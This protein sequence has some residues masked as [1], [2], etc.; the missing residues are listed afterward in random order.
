MFE[1]P[2]ESDLPGSLSQH[3]KNGVADF[4]VDVDDILSLPMDHWGG[5]FTKPE[6]GKLREDESLQL[7]EPFPGI[8]P[9]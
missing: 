1:T 2:S 4:W 5:G 3:R 9:S 6:A 7:S 8:Q